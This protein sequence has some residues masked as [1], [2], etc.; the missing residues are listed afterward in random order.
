M[1]ANTLSLTEGSG[2]LGGWRETLGLLI[3]IGKNDPDVL[4]A[5]RRLKTSCR[6]KVK[7]FS[8]PGGLKTAPGCSL[9]KLLAPRPTQLERVLP[10]LSARQDSQSLWPG[11]WVFILVIST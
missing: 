10:R 8:A 2:S 7:A 4:I 11:P 1:D 6:S 5:L 3:L 9:T